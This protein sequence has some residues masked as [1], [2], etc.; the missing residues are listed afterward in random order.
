MRRLQIM[1][2]NKFYEA[3]PSSPN[4]LRQL[5]QPTI[6]LKTKPYIFWHHIRKRLFSHQNYYLKL[7][8][9]FPL[10]LLTNWL[11][12]QRSINK[13]IETRSRKPSLNR[14]NGCSDLWYFCSPLQNLRSII[15]LDGVWLSWSKHYISE[16]LE[17][18]SKTLSVQEVITFSTL[19]PS[20]SSFYRLH[21]LYKVE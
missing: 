8:G 10:S 12:V 17:N 7:K 5:I 11:Q 21:H 18:F 3:S 1:I 19:S 13:A 4:W 9:R 20:N 2:R 6:E 14:K 16:P 15:R